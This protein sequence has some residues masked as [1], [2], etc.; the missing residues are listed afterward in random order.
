MYFSERT[1]WRRASLRCIDA[2]SKKS[3]SV[4]STVEREHHLKV[5]LYQKGEL[6]HV[7]QAREGDVID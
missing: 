5:A 7:D 3:R 2:L 4:E 6:Y 1:L